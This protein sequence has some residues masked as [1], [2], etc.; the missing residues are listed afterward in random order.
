LKINTNHEDSI[1]PQYEAAASALAK[2]QASLT[3]AQTELTTA[4]Q[5]LADHEAK[6][7]T[8]KTK[9]KDW[10][11]D[12]AE[13]SASVTWFERMVSNRAE[14][15]ATAQTE[16]DA[17]AKDL[18]LAQMQDRAEFVEGF[19]RAEFVARYAKRVAPIAGEAWDELNAVEDAINEIKTIARQAG[20]N[21]ADGYTAPDGYGTEYRFNGIRLNPVSVSS[22][23]V[24]D[25]LK[26]PENPRVTAAREQVEQE[27]REEREAERA[28]AEAEQAQWEAD[29]PKRAAYARYKEAH[30]AWEVRR[31]RGERNFTLL[32]YVGPEPIYG[33]PDTY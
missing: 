10:A 16:Y 2:T 20:I 6:A 27:R 33:Q 14:A 21:A 4:Q 9:P 24:E 12:G 25:A 31:L 19:E 17:R 23:A 3:E 18:A 13:L 1:R 30:D 15:V 32:P 7:E 29:A 8:A 22:S 28:R 11:H 5:K 26:A